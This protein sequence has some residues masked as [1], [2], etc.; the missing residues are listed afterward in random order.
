MIFFII[1]FH[2]TYISANEGENCDCE[3]LQLISE[4]TNTYRNLTKQ[5]DKINGRPFYFSE[6]KD[7]LWW[8]DTSNTWEFQMYLESLDTYLPIFQ[9]NKNFSCLNSPIKAA[10]IFAQSRDIGVIKAKCLENTIKC[11]GIH[12]ES[13]EIDQFQDGR[14]IIPFNATTKAPCVFPFKYGTKT[15]NSCKT[16]VS[17][18]SHVNHQS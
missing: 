4:G 13:G 3:I 10:E 16:E 2:Y 9:S 15:Y 7:I 14:N 17:G 12:E 6:I 1:C 5:S 11:L 18:S 8:N